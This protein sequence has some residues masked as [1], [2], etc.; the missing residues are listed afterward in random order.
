L[1][2]ELNRFLLTESSAGRTIV[3]V[4]DEAQNLDP[5]VLEQ[6]RLISNLETENDKLIQIIL[7]G[8]PELE[9]LLERPN[10]RQL[11]QR[12]AVRYKLQ[13]M[14]MTETAQYISQRMEVAGETGGVTF[15]T[16]AIKLIY[17]AT[18]GVPRIINILCD[19][20]LLIAYGDERRLITCVTV[21]RAISEVQ[22][23]SLFKKI[24]LVL[25]GLILFVLLTFLFIFKDGLRI[26]YFSNSPENQSI[27]S[28]NITSKN[29]QL[30]NTETLRREI[31]SFDQNDT[32]IIVFNTFSDL[33]NVRPLNN[34]TEELVIPDMFKSLAVKRKLRLT[35]FT[36]SLDDA[37]RF[38]LPFIAVTNVS[39][40][41]GEYCYAVTMAKNDFLTVSPALFEQE[42]ISKN[43]FSKVLNGTYY[44]VWQNFGL[45]PDSLSKGEKRDEIRTLQQL[46]KQGGF[47]KDNVN[48][49]YTTATIAAVR[50][51]QQSIKVTSNDSLGEITLAALSRFYT[52]Y[53]IPTLKDESRI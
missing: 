33:W 49:V 35:R 48:G 8:Q 52:T 12:I 47:Y 22:N 13:S 39:G 1:L 4:I 29:P 2:A 41:L 18:R 20:A 36:G 16:W 23:R 53:M 7:A 24:A 17:F 21:F 26:P 27:T 50:S 43:D 51:F 10:L 11:N 28:T 5:E 32:H 6:I 45:I 9:V 42:T 44:L 37:I 40:A 3:L 38:N 30:R 14:S 34:F 15:S 31:L 19:R 25:S 46:L